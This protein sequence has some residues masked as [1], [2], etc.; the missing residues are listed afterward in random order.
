MDRAAIERAIPH[1]S[2]YLFVDR[3]LERTDDA[4]T[5]EWD[6][7]GD[8]PALAGHYP[9]NPLL[10]GALISEFTFQCAA[11]LFASPGESAVVTTKMPVLTKIED[12]R[13]KKM[14][15]PGETLRAVVETIEKLGPARFMKAL[16]TSGGETVARL[17]FT[18][19]LVEKSAG[20]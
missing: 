11:I 3:V 13:F 1:R 2:P 4:L 6:I 14:V 10:P 15:A 7:R 17:K 8:M 9:G 18:V 20:A 5:A 12:A 16:V 19:A